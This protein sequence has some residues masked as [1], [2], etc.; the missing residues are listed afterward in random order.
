MSTEKRTSTQAQEQDSAPEL[1]GTSTTLEMTPEEHYELGLLYKESY[2]EFAKPHFKE[3]AFH[4]VPGALM[5]FLKISLPYNLLVTDKRLIFK[6][7][8]IFYTSE[9]DSAE[10]YFKA[11][12]AG[13]ASAMLK[14]SHCYMEGLGVEKDED[15]G[16]LLALQAAKNGAWPS[17]KSFHTWVTEIA[18][19]GNRQAKAYLDLP[20]TRELTRATQNPEPI[21]GTLLKEDKRSHS[22]SLF[23]LR[24]KP[25]QKITSNGLDLMS[26]EDESPSKKPNKI[27]FST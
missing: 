5:E 9:A 24:T 26:S 1:N 12:I 8:S 2:P 25:E 19:Q 16:F 6:S 15:M 17:K 3:A 20:Q 21:S 14:L 11:A 22:R 7:T 13:S 23:A 27:G 4:G 18:K 10:N